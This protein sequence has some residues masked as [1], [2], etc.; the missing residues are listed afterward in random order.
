VSPRNEIEKGPEPRRG[1]SNR[2]S[3]FV[4]EID[5][6]GRH[7]AAMCR[8]HFAAGSMRFVRVGFKNMLS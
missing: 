4:S 6:C 7:F 5:V 2:R 1:G 3:R 8:R